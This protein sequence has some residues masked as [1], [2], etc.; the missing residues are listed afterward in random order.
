MIGALHD[1]GQ[2]NRV[3]R[4]DDIDVYEIYVASEFIA[5]P[6]LRRTHSN[7]IL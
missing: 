2:A 3:T 5:L 7:R 4:K 6:F 1:E